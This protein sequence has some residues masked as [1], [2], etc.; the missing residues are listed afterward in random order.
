MIKQ[1]ASKY[2]PILCRFTIEPT[3]AYLV[4]IDG[5]TKLVTTDYNVALAYVCNARAQMGW[6]KPDA[7]RRIKITMDWRK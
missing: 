7:Y 3:V 5:L 1:Q 4:K 6:G 2:R